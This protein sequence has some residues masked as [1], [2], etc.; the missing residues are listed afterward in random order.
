MS[1]IQAMHLGFL[2]SQEN[3]RRHLVEKGYSLE[4]IGENINFVTSVGKTHKLAIT[5]RS[6]GKI[7]GFK[8]RTTG[9]HEPKYYNSTGLSKK[10]VLFNLDSRPGPKDLVVVEGELDALHATVKGLKNVVATGGSTISREQVED[11][12][13]HGALSFTL[14]FDSNEVEKNE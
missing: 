9:H 10:Q 4:F 11:A 12:V 8:F 6:C 13:K 7:L 14:L 3:L 2:P 5:W 1:E